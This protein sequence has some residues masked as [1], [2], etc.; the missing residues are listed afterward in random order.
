MSEVRSKTATASIEVIV[1]KMTSRNPTVDDEVSPYIDNLSGQLSA[2]FCV[3]P[4][5]STDFYQPPSLPSVDSSSDLDEIA[6]GQAWYWTEAWQE[7]IR[8]AEE[9]LASGRYEDYSSI[10]DF[11]DA[12]DD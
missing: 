6:L 2:F 8:E 10:D 11:I 9:D 7:R 4:F 3:Y 1:G 12:L 5:R